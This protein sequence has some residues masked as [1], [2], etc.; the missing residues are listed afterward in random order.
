MTKHWNEYTLHQWVLTRYI[1]EHG[2]MKCDLCQLPLE[3]GQRIIAI[4]NRNNTHH[5]HKKCQ[6]LNNKAMEVAFT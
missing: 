4:V 6:L 3:V 2:S 1:R 5:R